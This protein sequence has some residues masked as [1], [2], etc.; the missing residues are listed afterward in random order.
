MVLAVGGASVVGVRRSAETEFV[1]VVAANVLH[2]DPVLQG[3]TG[4]AAGDAID[5]TVVFRQPEQAAEEL[6]AGELVVGR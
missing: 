6:V 4:K 1:R 2:G 5:A 3:L